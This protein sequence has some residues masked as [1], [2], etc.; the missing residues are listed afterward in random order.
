MLLVCPSAALEKRLQMN[1]TTMG[2]SLKI[3]LVLCLALFLT[4][5]AKISFAAEIVLRRIMVKVQKGDTL[6]TLASRHYVKPLN[7]AAWNKL[8][9][10]VALKTGQ[11]IAILVSTTSSFRGSKNTRKKLSVNSDVKSSTGASEAKKAKIQ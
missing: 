11:S 1:Y 3:K 4:G 9:I 2:I 8:S 7:V 6:A 5:C 10:P